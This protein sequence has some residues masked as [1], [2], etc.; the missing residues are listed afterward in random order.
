MDFAKLQYRCRMCGK[1]FDAVGMDRRMAL[2]VLWE[3]E[4]G[5]VAERHSNSIRRFTMC[6]H[7]DKSVGV[8]DLI[9][10]VAD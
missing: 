3:L 6:A 10:I 9:G 7:T 1:T 8:A 4:R 2:E 5:E